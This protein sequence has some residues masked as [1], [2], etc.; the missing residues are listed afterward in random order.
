MSEG[1]WR[2]K[3]STTAT[4]HVIGA[5]GIGIATAGVS[6]CYAIAVTGIHRATGIHGATLPRHHIW[7]SVIDLCCAPI[8]EEILHRAIIFAF[9]VGVIRWST[10][11]RSRSSETAAVWT[12]NLLQALIFGAAH[13][14]TGMSLLYGRPWYIRLLLSTQT[15]DGLIL[16]WIYWRYGLESAIACHVASDLSLLVI[17]KGVVSLR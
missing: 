8:L 3:P 7:P 15:W 14:F 13:V 12:A 17:S 4:I 6:V 11:V 2:G 9:L 5:A 1:L 10:G 16:G